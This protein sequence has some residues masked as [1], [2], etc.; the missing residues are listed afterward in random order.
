[1]QSLAW[2]YRR[3]SHM[4]PPEVFHRCRRLAEAFVG[5]LHRPPSA[6]E[7]S[8]G[9][10][11]RGPCTAEY[12][13]GR[14]ALLGHDLPEVRLANWPQQARRQCLAEAD[15]L[16]AHRFSF[17]DLENEP[18]GREICWNRDPSGGGSFPLTCAPGVGSPGRAEGRD[19]KYVWELNRQQHLVRLGQAFVLTGEER[20]AAEVI[21]QIASWIDQCPCPQGVNWTSALEAAMRLISWVWAFELIR[22]SDSTTDEFVSLLCRS[23]YQQLDF[24]DRRYSLHSSA[25]NHLIG[26][27]SGVYVAAA[28]WPELTGAKQWRRRAQDILMRECLRQNSPDGVN[29]EQAFGYQLFVFDLLLLPALLGRAHNVPFPRQYWDRLESMAEFVAWVSDCN[30]NTPNVGDAD[31]GF[32]IRLAGRREHTTASFLNTAAGAFG[33]SD[34][35]AWAGG[36]FDEKGLWLLGNATPGPRNR[37][38]PPP[39]RQTRAFR[40]GGYCVFRTGTDAANEALLLFDCGGLGLDPLAGHAHADALSVTLSVAGQPILID[41]GTFTYADAAWRTYFKATA[42][43]NTLCFAEEGG[44]ERKA[45][46]SEA[47]GQARYEGAFMWG[48]R[49]RVTLEEFSTHKGAALARGRVVWWNGSRHGRSIRWLPEEGTILIDDSWSGD[50]APVIRFCVAANVTLRCEGSR[51]VA[52]GGPAE[53]EI[54][55]EGRQVTVEPAWCSEHY[56]RKCETSRICVETTASAGRC[57]TAL[58]WSIPGA[59]H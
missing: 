22:R 57:T 7:V 43:H 58:H 32:A 5:R 24:I 45:A 27:A 38:A 51:V 37:P 19:V 23:A 16:L 21:G 29:R 33:R 11:F 8:I 35:R 52:A 50:R 41:P 2:Y 34:F 30:A 46:G 1:M 53:V 9:D 15:D 4:P 44:W 56:G 28:Y 49:P 17:F 13:R 3:L 42:Q 36:A 18:L 40:Q 12:F 14:A 54:S 10:V 31:G 6:A 47:A 25:N 48:A 55:A 39:P 59:P 26:E 20:Y